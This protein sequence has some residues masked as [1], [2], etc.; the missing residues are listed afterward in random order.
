MKK[1]IQELREQLSVAAQAARQ[2]VEDNN[3]AWKPEHQSIYDQKM[4]E[5]EDIKAQIKRREAIA[6]QEAEDFQKEVAAEA[7]AINQRNGASPLLAKWLRGGDRALNAA[8]WA[9]VRNAMSTTEGSEGGFTVDQEVARTVVDALKAIGGV[10]AVATV[11]QTSGYGTLNYPTSN[12][13][14]EEGEQVA[15]NTGA[16]DEDVDFGVVPIAAYKYSS[17]VVTVPFELL[18]DSSVN[19]EAFVQ[20]RLNKRLARITNRKFTTGSG[21]DEPMGIVTAAPVGVPGGAISFEGMIDLIHSVDPAYREAGNCRFMLHDTALRDIR[22]LKDDQGRPLY[23]PG[24]DGLGVAMP[25]TVYGYPVAINQHMDAPGLGKKPV[26]FGDFSYYVVRDVMAVELFRFTDSAYTKKGQVGFLAWM[27]SG[28]AFTDV[29][30]AVKAL[31][32]AGAAT[33]AREAKSKAAE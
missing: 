20:G 17:K 24:Y 28:G 16:T 3:E 25:D 7:K 13:T 12:G 30:G 26:L 1:S 4:A 21:T 15:Q 6:E 2:V 18:Q 27:R 31:Q 9:Q 19:I 32:M 14:T 5:V 22:K 10:R 33:T 29:G 23:L 11:I 8:E